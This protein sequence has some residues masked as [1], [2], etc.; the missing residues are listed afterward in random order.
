MNYCELCNLACESV[1]CP[2]CGKRKLREIKDDDY[3]FVREVAELEKVRLEAYLKENEISPVFI[4]YVEGAGS[5]YTFR[6]P[7]NKM[8]VPFQLLEKTR[9]IVRALEE[10]TSA[11]LKS[12][13]IEKIPK[14]NI[15]AKY[16]KKLAKKLKL[17]SDVD[18]LNYCREIILNAVKVTDRSGEMG[19]AERA[20]YVYANDVCLIV[21]TVNYEI[22][23]VKK[24]K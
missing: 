9:D 3:C 21:S 19:F 14:L 16:A 8:Y 18:F 7:V 13:L 1:S 6:P 12:Q 24:I 5:F 15:E 22:L 2:K 20:I 17:P 4:P 11:E 23:T 10:E